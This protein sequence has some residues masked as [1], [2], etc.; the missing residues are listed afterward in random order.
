MLRF[1]VFCKIGKNNF[2]GAGTIIS[3]NLNTTDNTV[4][5]IG[6]LLLS[7]ITEEGVYYGRPAKK[8]K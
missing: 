4:V 3:D 1:V 8:I 6:S 7:S 5:G 2:I